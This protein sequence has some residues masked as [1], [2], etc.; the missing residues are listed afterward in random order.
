VAKRPLKLERQS[1]NLKYLLRFIS[2]AHIFCVTESEYELSV[3]M[4]EID[5]LVKEMVGK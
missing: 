3:T 5:N 2:I 4:R 1:R